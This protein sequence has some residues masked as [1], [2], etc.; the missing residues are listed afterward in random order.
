MAENILRAQWHELSDLGLEYEAEKALTLLGMLNTQQK[1]FDH[2]VDLARQMGSRQWQRITSMSA[3]AEKHRRYD[4]ALAVYEAG[5][6]PGQ[7]EAYLCKQYA[8]LQERLQNVER[9]KPAHRK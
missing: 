9:K 4:L 1:Q 7:P 2:F 5:L 3:M 8:E 6:E